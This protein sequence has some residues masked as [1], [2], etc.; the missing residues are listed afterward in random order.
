MIL[1]Y[2]FDS[3]VSIR[4]VKELVFDQYVIFGFTHLTPNAHYFLELAT[5][6]SFLQ[7][8]SSYI[9]VM[10]EEEIRKYTLL[11]HLSSHQT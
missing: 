9:H 7:S 8:V 5:Y 10:W 3:N 1:V 4:M 2:F 6:H 11:F